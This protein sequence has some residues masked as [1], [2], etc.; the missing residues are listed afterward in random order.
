MSVYVIEQGRIENRE[1]LDEYA[2]VHPVNGL[3]SS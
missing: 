2:K 1:V 3:A